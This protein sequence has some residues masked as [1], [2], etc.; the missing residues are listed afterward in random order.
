MKKNIFY[1]LA[2][3]L[4]LG[5][6]GCEKQE[7]ERYEN[8]PRLYFFRGVDYNR[9]PVF[10]Q[11]DSIT[12]S[13]FVLPEKQNRDTV[14]IAIETMG[15]TSGEA[16]PFRLIQTNADSAGAAVAGTH[17]VD[18]NSEEMRK[19]MIIPAG[20]VRYFMPLILLRDPSL[21]HSKVRLNLAIA[22]NEHFKVGINARSK[23]LI[24]ITALAEPPANWRSWSGTFGNWGS[25]KM[26]FLI[27]YVGIT[28]F[29]T[30]PTDYAYLNYLKAVAIE[31]L[32][33]YNADVNNEDAPLTEADGTPV[34]FE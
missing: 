23:F 34:T 20:S 11:F 8:D 1:I 22:E 25:K 16:R 6:A 32:Q 28:D 30:V 3:L 12:Q 14:Y 18:F 24:T 31:K 7:A 2:M 26:W 5:M 29:S 33:A 13:F 21:E 19:N 4:G 17:Y 27:N 10:Q 9:K 15:M